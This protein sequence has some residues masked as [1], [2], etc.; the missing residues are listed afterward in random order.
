MKLYGSLLCPDCPPA[1]E[2]LKS[3]GVS[4]EFINVTKDIMNFKEFLRLRD[5]RIEFEHVIEGGYIG[6]PCLV[7]EDG[8]IL[9][10]D[11]IEEKYNK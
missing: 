5:S 9:F 4:F 10:Q 1:I 11:E 6:I 2:L 7:E 8:T 3:K